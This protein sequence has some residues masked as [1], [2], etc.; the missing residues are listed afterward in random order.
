METF[1]TQLAVKVEHLGPFILPHHL[2]N[3][4]QAQLTWGP[5]DTY[6]VLRGEIY[7]PYFTIIEIQRRYLHRCLSYL[8]E[9]ASTESHIDTP[10]HTIPYNKHIPNY[11][12]QIQALNLEWRVYPQAHLNDILR[13]ILELSPL[14]GG[15]WEMEQ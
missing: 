4:Y 10:Q 14:L 6:P 9:L 11:V 7:A 12:K 15:G 2:D 3:F 1:N 5:G 13:R 8:L